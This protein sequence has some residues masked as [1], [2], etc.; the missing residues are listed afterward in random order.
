MRRITVLATG[1]GGRSVGHQLLQALSLAGDRYRIVA[2]DA[3]AFS[4]GL[5]QVDARRLLPPA[6]SP[7]YLDAVER[8]VKAENVAAILPGSQPETAVLAANAA[9]FAGCNV[10]SHNEAGGN[11]TSSTLTGHNAAGCQ[12]ICNP[13]NVVA[14]CANKQAVQD[15]LEANGFAVPRSAPGTQWRR[16]ATQV[17]FPLVVKPT[18]DT[19]GSRGVAIV[20]DEAEA[21]AYL[22]DAPPD[23]VIFQEYV[24]DIDS[25][26]TV[27]VL[28]SKSGA[29][30]DSIVMHRQLVGLSLGVKREIHGK[31]YGLSTGYSQGFIV[32]HE[33][34]QRACEDLAI[35]LGAR[36]PLNI[37]LRMAAGKVVVFEVHPRFSG[38]SS[39]RAQVGFNEPDVL[40]RN[41]LFDE[42]FGRLTYQSDVAAIRGLSNLIV[43]RSQIGDVPKA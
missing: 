3:S 13:P 22:Q 16:L 35:R 2:A 40:I 30:I 31:V 37:Q 1:V 34:I 10:T 8:L 29:V 18:E 11:T 36:G 38:S 7:D 5:Y 15:W 27:G 42:P 12:V 20:K 39:I 28:I 43:P 25:E 4:Y 6:N 21:I 17:G 14:L 19:G 32:R 23:R 41:F 9:R 24:G 33:Q 26:F